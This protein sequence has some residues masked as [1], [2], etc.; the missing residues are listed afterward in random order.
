MEINNPMNA[1]N[2]DLTTSVSCP[3][4][5]NQNSHS[6]GLL[7]SKIAAMQG[8]P[9]FII[10]RQ[11]NHFARADPAYAAEVARVLIINANLLNSKTLQ[12]SLD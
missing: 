8:V 6:A 10:D 7:H 1:D 11:L 4:L 9:Q 3:V 12:L 2:Q 5:N